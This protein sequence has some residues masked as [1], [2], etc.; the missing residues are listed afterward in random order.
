ML[1]GKRLVIIDDNV[2]TGETLDDLRKM[3]MAYSS[4]V[5]IAAVER[6]TDKP[7][8]RAINFDDL[9]FKPISKLR[10]IERVVEYIKTHNLEK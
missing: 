10:Y 2:F 5:E 7:T 6:L 1:L 4:Q 3:C 8:K 9:D